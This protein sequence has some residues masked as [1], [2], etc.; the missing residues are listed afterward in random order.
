MILRFHFSLLVAAMA[1]S[2]NGCSPDISGR[3]DRP[4]EKG[5]ADF[6]TFVA[7]GDSLTAGYADGALY[8][9]GQLNSFPAI[10]AQ[11][12]ALAG[13]GAFTQP[14]MLPEK[15]G[16]LT[17]NM[18]DLGRSDRLVLVATGDPDSPAAPA[19][20][21]PA[22]S[23]ELLTE[24]IPGLYNN[25]GVPGAKIFHAPLAGYGDPMG[26]PIMTAN[27]YFARFAS[28]PTASPGGSSMLSD[29]IAQT[30][31]FF[32]LWLGNNDLLLY[33]TDGADGTVNS[34]F[35]TPY[36][37]MT[38]GFDALLLGLN[39]ATNKGLIINIPDVTTIPYFTTVSYNAI[40]LTAAQAQGLQTM[41]GDPYNMALDGLVG[42]PIDQAEANKRHLNFVEGMNPVLI[43]DAEDLVDLTPG[44]P[45][46]R[47]ATPK[48]F[49]VLPASRKI[50][51]D[52]GGQYGIS[53]PLVD[54]DVLSEWEVREEI[55][56]VRIPFNR[57]V[58]A[59]AAA[60]P[61]LLFF[62]ASAKLTELNETGILYG[63]GGVS[64]TFAQGGFFSLDGIHPT[65]RGNAVIANEIFKLIN[66][67]FDAYI[68]PV[69]P[70]DYPTVF[71]Q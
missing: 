7:I 23:S 21:T 13:G 1:L 46:M 58:E 28:N 12:F 65:A 32:L 27:P 11:Q 45:S 43:T 47:H 55:E 56:D 42:G 44:L 6:S 41:L 38:A 34:E 16:S 8:R 67:G 57:Y 33:A 59:A 29:A 10:M 24:S 68:P 70:S 49:I 60:D 31:S 20:I 35:V 64:S 52:S 15:T 26:I 17:L 3:Y 18:N 62:D 4:A 51:V 14:E 9:D 39:P 5:S 53:V 66:A 22:V 2:L 48:D 69:D 19:T 50:G 71:Y 63:S 36:A 40:P 61:D 25:I 37:N 30:P 54:S